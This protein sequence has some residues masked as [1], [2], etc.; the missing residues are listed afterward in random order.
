VFSS[1]GLVESENG[2]A[3]Q[4]VASFTYLSLTDEKIPAFSGTSEHV[5]AGKITEVAGRLPIKSQL[6]CQL[7]Y[8]PVRGFSFA[9]GNSASLLR[10]WAIAHIAAGKLVSGITVSGE[11]DCR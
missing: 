10:L 2:S 9:P 3:T 6:L 7:S 8:A 5:S 11:C 4:T 1:S